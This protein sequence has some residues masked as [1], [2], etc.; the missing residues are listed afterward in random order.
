M[1][2]IESITADVHRHSAVHCRHRCNTTLSP[3]VTRNELG[4]LPSQTSHR[5]KLSS[6]GLE[7][8]RQ[9]SLQELQAHTSIDQAAVHKILREDLHMLKVVPRTLPEQK[10]WCCYETCC[11]HLEWYQNEGDNLLNNIITTDET[12]VR[13]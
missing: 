6:P 3:D 2:V 8:D 13:A 1:L 4:A 9:W 10:I 5:L 7:D 11:I 12:W